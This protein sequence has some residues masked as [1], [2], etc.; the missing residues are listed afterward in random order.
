MTG[1]VVRP[2]VGA[3]LPLALL[4]GA[5]LAS[6]CDGGADETKS[7]VASPEPI[8]HP[9]DYGH[10]EDEYYEEIAQEEA[11]GE[12]WAEGFGEGQREGYAGGYDDGYDDGYTQGY[13]DGFYEGFDEGCTAL[14]D[15]LIQ[16][17]LLDWYECP[18]Y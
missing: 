18:S 8:N 15:R 7:G 16:L 3:F 2:A 5:A 10:L 4:V 6:A 11:I 14:G 12:A 1:G 9:S 17:G 13:D